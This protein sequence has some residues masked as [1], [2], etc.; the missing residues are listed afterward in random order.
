[1][2]LAPVSPARFRATSIAMHC[3]PRQR[4]SS[5]IPWVRAWRD[6]ADLPLDAADAEAAGDEHPVHPV[7]LAR[8]TLGVSQSSL[9]TH[10]MLTL[11]SLANPP[12]R[13][14]SVGDR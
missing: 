9:G 14:A 8:R 3:R 4:P 7:E 6:R 5:G 1:M 10:R 13:S 11:A 2:L 12:A